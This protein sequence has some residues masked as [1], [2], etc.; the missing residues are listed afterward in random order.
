MGAWLAGNGDADEAQRL[1]FRHLSIYAD[2]GDKEGVYPRDIPGKD[3]EGIM[4]TLNDFYGSNMIYDLTRQ[5]ILQ[6]GPFVYDYSWLTDQPTEDYA[7]WA[8]RAF[9]RL[10]GEHPDNATII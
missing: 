4:R 7:D 10:Y 8:K 2:R 1:F 6:R 9:E 5:W 3:R